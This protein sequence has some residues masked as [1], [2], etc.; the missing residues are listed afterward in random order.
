[1]DREWLAQ[2]QVASFPAEETIRTR[3]P[4]PSPHLISHWF[5]LIFI[6]IWLWLCAWL[7]VFVCSNWYTT[8]N[9]DYNAVS[10]DLHAL[11]QYD[12]I[13]ILTHT[14]TVAFNFCFPFLLERNWYNCW[15]WLFVIAWP[16]QGSIGKMS[17]K[18]RR[19]REIKCQVYNVFYLL[20][21]EE[22]SLIL[23]EIPPTFSKTFEDA[24]RSN[25]IIL[26]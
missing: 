16:P 8:G 11:N 14:H 6:C 17:I 18:K 20:E 15:V 22:A 24:E 4:I 3:L 25:N 5:S 19:Q 12:C 7:C 23:L 13:Y 1:M 21:K 9:G 26:F 10:I 2:N